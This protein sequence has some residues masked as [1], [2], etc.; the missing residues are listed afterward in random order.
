MSR[1]LSLSFSLHAVVTVGIYHCFFCFFCPVTVTGFISLILEL[2]SLPWVLWLEQAQGFLSKRQQ[3]RLDEGRAVWMPCRWSCQYGS[4]RCC[5]PADFWFVW[6]GLIF[7]WLCGD[8][9]G[10]RL[11]TSDTMHRSFALGSWMLKR[12]TDVPKRW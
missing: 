5:S 1:S 2:V 12:W 8:A 9:V 7:L 10:R 6:R 3:T 11:N 4:R